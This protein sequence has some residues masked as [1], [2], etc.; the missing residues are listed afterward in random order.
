MKLANRPK[1][2]QARKKSLRWHLIQIGVNPG[3]RLS[4]EDIRQA[5]RIFR[6]AR[7]KRKIN[8]LWTFIKKHS[9]HVCHGIKLNPRAATCSQPCKIKQMLRTKK[10]NKKLK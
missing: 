5:H 8:D 9:C 1:N 2:C 3:E 10:W 4:G 6:L 7:G